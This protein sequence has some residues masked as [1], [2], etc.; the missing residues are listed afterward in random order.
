M[1]FRLRHCRNVCVSEIDRE[2]RRRVEPD[3]G[4]ENIPLLD[5]RYL[6]VWDT[7]R[8]L[9][10]P[11]FLPFSAEL[12]RKYGFHDAVLTSKVRS[13]RHAVALDERRPTFPPT[14]FG[15]DKIA[16]LN[17]RAGAAQGMAFD[18]WRAPYQ[19]R[20]FPGVHGAIGGGGIRTG[21]SDA[22]LH[23]VLSGAR[24]AGL[25]LRESMGS[26][27]FAIRPDP[28]DDV[29]NDPPTAFAR[30]QYWLFDKLGIARKG[31]DRDTAIAHAAY[32]K[33]H[34]ADAAAPY[35]PRSLRR[36]RQLIERWPYAQPPEWKGDGGSS[37]PALEEFA[38]TGNETLSSLARDRL[39]DASRW[40]ELFE[41]NRDRLEDPDYLPTEIVLRLPLRKGG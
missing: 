17:D 21:L 32:R 36:A 10:V 16:E 20:W 13:A 1:R 11:D 25:R 34:R 39:G 18:E 35:R 19:E 23:W 37:P 9:G 29:M 28:F 8:A 7:V 15:C 40:P 33:W 6:G 2:F 31:P 41:L 12:N 38:T 27:A 5:I 30:L 3:G 14:L 22:A 24:R 26:V 4:H